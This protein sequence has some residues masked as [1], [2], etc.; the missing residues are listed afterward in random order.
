[1]INDFVIDILK[2][3]Y[4]VSY[5]YDDFKNYIIVTLSKPTDTYFQRT[6]I[7][8]TRVNK[9]DNFYEELKY[10]LN[11]MVFEYEYKIK[12]GIIDD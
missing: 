12:K 8:L 10:I 11:R 9:S 7:D 3:G 5:S 6:A 2:Q 4:R 1:M